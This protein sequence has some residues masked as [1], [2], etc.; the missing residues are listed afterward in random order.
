MRGVV[1]CIAPV[2]ALIAGVAGA[3]PADPAMSTAALVSAP[4]RPC[5]W[6][7][8]LDGAKDVLTLSVTMKNAGGIPLPFCTFRAN[9]IPIDGTAFA[10]DPVVNGATGAAGVGVVSFAKLGGCGRFGI[11]IETDGVIVESIGPF[12]MTS[13]DL[14]GSGATNV[15]DL[16]LFAG[17]L[18]V[19]CLCADY[20]C[21]GFVNIIDLGIW[22]GGLGIGC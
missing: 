21:D 16:G 11:Q 7:F 6:L 4:A 15:V 14:N 9:V 12:S 5:H 17:C 1:L 18:A 8:Q 3:C 10:C 2:A 19:P 22:A 13:S 20:N